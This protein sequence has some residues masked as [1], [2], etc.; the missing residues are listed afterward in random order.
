MLSN[1]FFYLL[2]DTT[3][4]RITLAGLPYTMRGIDYEV[5]IIS[6]EA[7]DPG[8]QSVFAED[9]NGKIE[10]IIMSLSKDGMSLSGTSQFLALA[11]G[12]VTITAQVCDDVGNI[13]NVTDLTINLLDSGF[14]YCDIE[15]KAADA[16]IGILAAT[17]GI[18][19]HAPEVLLDILPG[20]CE[21]S[22]TA[23]T[24][25]MDTERVRL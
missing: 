4:P 20:L 1:G 11:P 13:S 25:S 8:M 21:I 24:V 15:A 12:P 5:T 3:G 17:A 9:K 19:T 18:E 14:Y 10:Q 7:M 6:N 2:L 16:D 22:Y 23:A